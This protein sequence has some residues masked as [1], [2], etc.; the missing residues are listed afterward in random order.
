MSAF[1][2]WLEPIQHVQP[3]SQTTGT[4][5]TVEGSAE[6]LRYRTIL[7]LHGEFDEE[8]P[9]H[10]PPL[11]PGQNSL[12]TRF[13]F[14]PVRHHDLDTYYSFTNRFE[15]DSR[16][17]HAMQKYDYS[18]CIFGRLYKSAFGRSSPGVR[19][20]YSQ[21]D[22]T[23]S[24][25]AHLAFTALIQAYIGLLQLER[26][27]WDPK[28]LCMN[29]EQV[30]EAYRSFL[31]SGYPETW[32]WEVDFYAEIPDLEDYLGWSAGSESI[33][34]HQTT[35]YAAHPV[36]PRRASEEPIDVPQDIPSA[37][38][39]VQPR[40]LHF[41]SW[42]TDGG[43]ISSLPMIPLKVTST[44]PLDKTV[45]SRGR[46]RTTSTRGTSRL[47]RKDGSTSRGAGRKKG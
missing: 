39:D 11:Q 9:I 2:V 36:G 41:A 15:G 14:R 33:E 25:L 43:K 19:P 31:A 45:S 1:G 6:P 42:V 46:T 3:P 47:G 28:S 13:P 22:D 37:E 24:Q 16:I 30:Y 40:S 7:V 21:S 4:D 23:R 17:R 27:E 12:E 35:S 8:V 26:Q 34:R 18:F 10:T 5:P 32:R 29:V 20:S 44:T 38:Q